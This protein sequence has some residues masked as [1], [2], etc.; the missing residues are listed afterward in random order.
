MLKVENN[1]EVE[2]VEADDY[3]VDDDGNLL[4][5]AQKGRRKWVEVGR[6]K[7]EQWDRVLP[8]RG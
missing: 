7:P 3:W 1:G 2:E 4:L 8:V 5:I 6:I